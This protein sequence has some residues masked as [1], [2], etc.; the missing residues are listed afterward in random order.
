MENNLGN[1]NQKEQS[2]QNERLKDN[3][4]SGFNISLTGIQKTKKARKK[5]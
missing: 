1:S 4:L 3:K 5:Y 2:M